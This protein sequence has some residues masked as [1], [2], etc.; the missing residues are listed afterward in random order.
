M[1]YYLKGEAAQKKENFIVLDIGGIGFK[2]FSSQTSMNAVTTGKETML[3]TYTYIR[4]DAF[5]IYGFSSMEELNL[6]QNLI[7]ISGVGPKAA[8]A[9]LS[10][11]SVQDIVF[12]VISSDAKKL[13]QAPGIGPKLAQRII[14]ELKDKMKDA[15]I[16]ETLLPSTA[17]PTEGAEAIGAL[18]A[19]GYSDT[20]ARHAVSHAGD[21]LSLE[22]TI[23]KALIYLSR[24]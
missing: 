12:I 19:L 18:L 4:E 14:L 13:A 22:D 8:L 10:T 16:E 20:E 2:V 24:R 23:K 7:S 1:F 21:G 5:D 3:Y 15:E 6:F 9:I 11:H 17:V